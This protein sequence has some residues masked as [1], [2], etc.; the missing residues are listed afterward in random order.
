MKPST[1]L[2]ILDGYVYGFGLSVIIFSGVNGSIDIKIAMAVAVCAIAKFG[3]PHYR[4]CTEYSMNRYL[5]WYLIVIG[6]VAIAG[7]LFKS[8]VMNI[9]L[10]ILVGC[11]ACLRGVIALYKT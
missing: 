11:G 5:A 2:L 9:G 6:L 8:D 7:S 4:N 1:E 10:L 3:W